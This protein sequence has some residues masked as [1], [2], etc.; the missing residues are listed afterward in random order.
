M[1]VDQKGTAARS[2]P[3][4]PRSH[5][6]A[7]DSSATKVVD[8]PTPTSA[9]VE[10]ETIVVEGLSPVLEKGE[11]EGGGMQLEDLTVKELKE[12]AKSSGVALSSTSKKKDIV[13]ALVDAG[14][15][16]VG[17]HEEQASTASTS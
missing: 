4:V 16:A 14:V 12:I 9:T 7:A 1:R 11:E 3:E 17:K 8:E 6:V 13:S 10:E 2:T 5:N 15:S